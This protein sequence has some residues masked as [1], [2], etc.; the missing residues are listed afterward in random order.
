MITRTFG[1]VSPNLPR[2][3]KP[4]LLRTVL[5]VMALSL[6]ACEEGNAGR[7]PDAIEPAGTRPAPTAQTQASPQTG[8]NT[9]EANAAEAPPGGTYSDCIAEAASQA[10]SD[11]EREVLERTCRN[12]PGAP[13][14]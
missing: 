14:Q 11:G 4:T 8:A 12:L 1:A 10:K 13:A 2:S 9:P 5:L 3:M 7:D 6:A